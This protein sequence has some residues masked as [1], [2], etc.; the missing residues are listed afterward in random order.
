MLAELRSAGAWGR[1]GTT[2]D[3]MH[4]SGWPTLYTGVSPGRHG[5]YHAYQVRGGSRGVQ[6]SRP[7]SCGSPPFWKYLDDAG[8]RCLVFDAFM[9]YPLDGFGGL[10]ILEYG[11]WTWFVHPGARPARLWKEIVRRFGPYPGVEHLNVL[12]IP[13]PAWFRDKLVEGATDLTVRFAGNRSR[14]QQEE[15]ARYFAA[16]ALLATS[17]GTRTTTATRPTTGPTRTH[18]TRSW[19][20]TRKWT[21]RSVA[22][23]RRSTM[24]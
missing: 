23:S 1:L 21:A 7:E 22:S 3:V 11:T 9:T 8:K 10:Q 12:D 13:D 14:Q 2:A 18:R 4:V 20:Y 6:R 15:A 24:M 16:T 5:L 17:C 19:T